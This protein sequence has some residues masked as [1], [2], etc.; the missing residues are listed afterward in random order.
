M[1][2]LIREIARLHDV[3]TVSLVAP[4]DDVDA[5]RA[6]LGPVIPVPVTLTARQPAGLAKRRK[7]ARSLIS[8]SSF[9]YALYVHRPL[10]EMLDRVVREQRIDLVQLE[11][12]QMGAYAESLPPGVA[13]VLDIHNIEYDV[14]G[15]MARSSSVG[16]RLFNQIEY[17]KF[18]HEEQAAWRRAT[19][20]VVTSPDD[21]AVVQTVTGRIVPVIPNGVDTDV[22]TQVP[23]TEA[24][25]LSIVFVGAMR[26][27]P[28]AE[29]ARWFAMDV[30]PEI[31]RR[32]PGARFAIVG[33]DPPPDVTSLA[34]LP[35]VT[36]A[37]TVPDVRPWLA[38]AGTVV[39]PLR[40]GGGTR[41]KILEAFAA[42]RPVVATTLGAA[43]LDVRDG[44]HLLIA[45][46]APDLANAVY[47]I[48][49][50]RTL[51]RQLV[52][53]ARD[54][55]LHRYRWQA[56]ADRLALVYDRIVREPAD[57]R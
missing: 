30:L 9:Q 33:A 31:R 34:A 23:L 27:R 57:T 4:G 20:C 12:S 45:D 51:G 28:N 44:Q 49:T 47:R 42:G 26:Y 56:I 46:S 10:R 5:A 3:T 32:L 53:N 36:V 37:G 8:R 35:G 48:A 11:F 50:N 40:A 17:R 39:V 55:V 6:V 7:Q 1:D 19:I 18:R 41:L 25:P 14:L 13:S 38:Q 15:Q 52:E 29:A 2:A 21:A 22:F 24:D 43:G 16:R 54:L